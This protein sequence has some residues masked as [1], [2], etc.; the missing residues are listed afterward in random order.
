MVWG[1][2]LNGYVDTRHYS[3]SVEKKLRTG[4]FGL[5]DLL[6]SFTHDGFQWTGGGSS[7]SPS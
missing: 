5:K 6:V 4:T 7:L 1:L 3:T 2:V